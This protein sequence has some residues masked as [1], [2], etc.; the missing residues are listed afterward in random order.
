MITIHELKMRLILTC[1]LFGSPLF[2]GKPLMFLIVTI[3]ITFLVVAIA[4]IA[5]PCRGYLTDL[6]MEQMSMA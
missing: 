5:Y 4:N 3:C 6:T 1:K 2:G